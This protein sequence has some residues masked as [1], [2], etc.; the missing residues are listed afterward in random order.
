MN[1]NKSINQEVNGFK[2]PYTHEEEEEEEV[3]QEEEDD[4]DDYESKD[5]SK[6]E[7]SPQN[8]K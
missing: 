5:E 2:L 6:F 4:N 8:A 1:Q 7:L 3:D